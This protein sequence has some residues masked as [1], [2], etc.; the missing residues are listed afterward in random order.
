MLDKLEEIKH[1]PKLTVEVKLTLKF[2]FSI[3]L[4]N[5]Y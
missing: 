5:I 3:N 2:S 4:F 1:F